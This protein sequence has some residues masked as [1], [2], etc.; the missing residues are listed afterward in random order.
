MKLLLIDSTQDRLLIAVKNGEQIEYRF[1]NG[2]KGST[3]SSIMPLIQKAYGGVEYDMSLSH[4]EGMDYV[5]VPFDEAIM[6][7]IK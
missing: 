3:S 6:R 4:I 1:G 7:T 2:D 5:L